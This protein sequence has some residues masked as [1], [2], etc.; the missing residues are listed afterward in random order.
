MY[1]AAKRKM[2]KQRWVDSS[3]SNPPLMEVK[4]S[5]S[6][7]KSSQKVPLGGNLQ[8]DFNYTMPIDRVHVQ[9]GQQPVPDPRD[10]VAKKQKKEAYA[11]A[12]KL[13][14][15]MDEHQKI[16]IARAKKKKMENS[17]QKKQT[18]HAATTMARKAKVV[19]VT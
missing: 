13:L 14:E 5:G 18:P 17:T 9:N 15:K 16:K 11:R 10:L 7:S 2:N 1:N 4:A 19:K 12:E 8:M 3:V 6:S